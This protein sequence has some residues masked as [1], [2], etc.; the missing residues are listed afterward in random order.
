MKEQT[1]GIARLDDDVSE[2]G[3]K[4]T[5]KVE[6]RGPGARTIGHRCAAIQRDINAQ[7]GF[8]LEAFDE[9]LVRAGQHAPV[10]MFRVVAQPV[11]FVIGKLGARPAQRTAMRAGKIAF[12]G[13]AG[14]QHEPAQLVHLRGIQ[15]RGD[16]LW[17]LLLRFAGGS[18]G[19]G[20]HSGPGENF[21]MGIIANHHDL[22]TDKS[23]TEIGGFLP[24]S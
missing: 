17:F 18:G 10:D 15:K 20:S 3:G 5:G 24:H 2:R 11:R 12:H 16:A 9:I 6:L 8:V 19:F 23:Q 13:V 14:E 4:V 7:V 1:D 21:P 22:R